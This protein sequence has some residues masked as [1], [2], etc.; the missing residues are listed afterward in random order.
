MPLSSRDCRRC[1]VAT[2]LYVGTAP[3]YRFRFWAQDVPIYK[4]LLELN[5]RNFN[6]LIFGRK[7]SLFI[8]VVPV[9]RV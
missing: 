5:Y 9:W 8:G 7:I 1:R 3:S 4:R 2:D 6:D